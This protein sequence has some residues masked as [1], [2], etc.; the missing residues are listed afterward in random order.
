[1]ELLNLKSVKT[2]QSC[3]SND[4]MSPN[5][6]LGKKVPNVLLQSTYFGMSLWLLVLFNTVRCSFWKILR[7]I[8]HKA[9]Y[10]E[11]CAFRVIDELLPRRVLRCS[12]SIV[13]IWTLLAPK[14][15]DGNGRSAKLKT[16][17]CENTSHN[18]WCQ[19]RFTLVVPSISVS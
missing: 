10:A 3:L 13:W 17:E 2:M 15:Q 18:R 8:D 5:V 1:M 4:W 14:N 11:G 16:S 19:G 9:R 6:S 7:D 12:I